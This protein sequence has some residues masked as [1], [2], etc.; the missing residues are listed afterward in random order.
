M[1]HELDMARLYRVILTEGVPLSCSLAY[2]VH[3]ILLK[4]L[5]A[6]FFHQHMPAIGDNVQLFVLSLQV[7]KSPYE[8]C[9]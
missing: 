8:M 2:P 7:G 1:F 9:S 5:G 3:G 6:L 4:L